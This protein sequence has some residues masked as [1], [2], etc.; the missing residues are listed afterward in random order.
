MR[1]TRKSRRS[2]FV[3]NMALDAL[4]AALSWHVARSGSKA[5]GLTHSQRRALE[6]A[7]WHDAE[8]ARLRAEAWGTR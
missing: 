1:I 6:E 4:H 2:S 5:K 8:A 7:D 3:L